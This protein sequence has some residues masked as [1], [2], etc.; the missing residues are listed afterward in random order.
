MPKTVK[1]RI[2]IPKVAGFHFDEAAHTYTLNGRPLHGVTTILKVINKPALVQWSA[3]VACDYITNNLPLCWGD[4]GKT[5]NPEKFGEVVSEA[6]TAHNKKKE[7]AGT[8]GTDVHGMLETLIKNAIEKNGGFVVQVETGLNNQVDT[9]IKWA[10]ENNVRFLD[11][12]K[13]LYSE[14]HWYAGTADFVCEI[15]GKLYVGDIKTSSSIYPEYFIQA[16]AYAHALE[17][18]NLYKGFHGVVIVNVP[19]KGGLNVR[20]NYDLRGNFDCFKAC[21]VI[22]NQ[23]NAIK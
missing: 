12:E 16:S 17:E 13:R 6:R 15:D 4:D 5:W 23:L 22:H 3:N 11:S 19:K 10:S 1:K 14:T 7:D 21:L 20:E 18:M 8:Q 9:F 2:P